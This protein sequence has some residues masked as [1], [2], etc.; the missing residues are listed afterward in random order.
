MS[1]NWA[2]YSSANSCHHYGPQGPQ[3][4]ITYTEDVFG[5]L[6]R[7]LGICNC[8]NVRGGSSRS[9]HAECR[10]ADDG[11]TIQAN[12]RWGYLFAQILGPHG[13]RLGIDHL[14]TNRKPWASGRGEPIIYSAK[15]PSGRVY[16]GTHP[17][18]DHNH[19]G[20]TRS[21][22]RNLTYG[23][24]V[25]VLGPPE[26]VARQILGRATTDPQEDDLLGFDI[27]KHGD[28]SVTGDRALALQ[29]MLLDRGM[30]LPQ[31]GADGAAGDETRDALHRFKVREGV[32][33]D[34]S[35]GS[36]IVGPHTY[37]ALYAPSDAAEAPQV[38]AYTKAQSD[39]RYAR[40]NHPHSIEVELG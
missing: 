27:G 2:P 18:K 21:A 16:T 10:A 13:R 14:I 23:T 3:A 1:F 39:D 7:S 20:F 24:L 31:W 26:A 9:H 30:D 40:K 33:A 37:R 15:S 5:A 12:K 11:F 6:H 25:A 19:T 35:A 34:L 4:L 8:R 29:L 32:S 17:H 38:D 28:P 36:G 22:A